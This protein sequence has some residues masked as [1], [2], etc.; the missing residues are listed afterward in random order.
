MTCGTVARVGLAIGIGLFIELG[1][2]I[3]AFWYGDVFTFVFCE[4][5]FFGAPVCPDAR[6]GRRFIRYGAPVV[7]V[8]IGGLLPPRL[9]GAT[10]KQTAILFVVISVVTLFVVVTPIVIFTA[11]IRAQA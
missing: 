8:V 6:P 1:F 5:S 4:S 9:L 2:L 3:F 11:R 7:G 10:W